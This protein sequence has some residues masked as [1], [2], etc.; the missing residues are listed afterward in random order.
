MMK[1]SM[2]LPAS[3]VMV[4]WLLLVASGMVTVSVTSLPAA[5]VVAESVALKLPVSDTE[6]PRSSVPGL[7]RMKSLLVFGLP[8]AS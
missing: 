3:G 7:D 4:T 1:G 8:W 5:M 2:P 6:T